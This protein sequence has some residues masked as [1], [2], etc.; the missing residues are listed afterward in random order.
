MNGGQASA[1]PNE[2]QAG[3][4]SAD[5]ACVCW[6]ARGAWRVFRGVQR[7]RSWQ[8]GCANRRSRARAE[9]RFPNNVFARARWQA[10]LADV[11]RTRMD[12]GCGAGCG[13]TGGARLRDGFSSFSGRLKKTIEL[14]FGLARGKAGARSLAGWA[15]RRRGVR[16]RG[17][18]VRGEWGGRGRARFCP[19][20]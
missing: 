11:A 2:G 18:G 8:R 15:E 13:G 12:S 5:G 14:V 3:R 1:K 7:A 16:A 6:R 20:A 4:A 17:E 10:R 9:I 19:R